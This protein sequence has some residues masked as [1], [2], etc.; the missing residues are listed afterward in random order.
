MSVAEGGSPVR[1]NVTLKIYDILGQ[2]IAALVNADQE[3]GYKSVV[4][5]ATNV[6]SGTYFCRFA[7]GN[8][9]D[10]RKMLIIK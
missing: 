6:P 5:D 2:E 4:W 9:A 3:P 1:S 7:A 8:F 10:V